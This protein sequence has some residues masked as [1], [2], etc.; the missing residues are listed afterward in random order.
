[1]PDNF[2]ANQKLKH[3]TEGIIQMPLQQWQQAWGN[4]NHARKTVPVFDH[5]HSKEIFPNIYSELPLV[6][7]CAIPARPLVGYHAKRPVP[8]FCSLSLLRRLQRAMRSLLAS[9]SPD[10][11][12][13][14]FSASLHRTCLPAFWQ[15]CCSPLDAVKDL[16][17]LFI[18]VEPRTACNIHSE[19]SEATPTLEME[20]LYSWPLL[21]GHLCCV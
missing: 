21:T 14:V 9:S 2:R 18:T 19:A 12:T 4:N 13:Q 1:M 3:I 15:L 6:Q 20:N 10:W 16:N 8:L 17:I 7:L 5:A 11:A